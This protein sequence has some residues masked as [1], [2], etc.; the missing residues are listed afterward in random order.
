MKAYEKR[1][2]ILIHCQDLTLYQ[3]SLW[4]PHLLPS[5]T[6][7][8][9]QNMPSSAWAALWMRCTARSDP[10][11][12]KC[13]ESSILMV[14]EKRCWAS[15]AERLSSQYSWYEEKPNMTWTRS[16][17]GKGNQKRIGWQKNCQVNKE[18]WEGWSYSLCVKSGMSQLSTVLVLSE[19]RMS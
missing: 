2:L 14:D 17:K 11:A 9:L 13:I 16:L 19:V 1:R 12:I 18:R 15:T 10:L 4:F 6:E 3:Q 7:A 8:T 5:S